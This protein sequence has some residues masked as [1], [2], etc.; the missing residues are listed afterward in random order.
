MLVYASTQEPTCF[1]YIDLQSVVNSLTVDEETKSVTV[2][3]PYGNCAQEDLSGFF[4]LI[5]QYYK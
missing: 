3:I 4:E 1:Y 2:R 5:N